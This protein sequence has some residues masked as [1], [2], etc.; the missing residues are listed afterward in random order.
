MMAKAAPNLE[1]LEQMVKSSP[2][3][4]SELVQSIQLEALT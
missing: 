3:Q 4:A 1:K 2:A